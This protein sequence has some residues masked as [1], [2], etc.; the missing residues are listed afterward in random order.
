MSDLLAQ[1][2]ELPC[3]ADQGP[4]LPGYPLLG[5][6]AVDLPH[7]L[8]IV[9]AHT[10]E[11]PVQIVQPRKVSCGRRVALIY[12]Q[13]LTQQ[14]P[15]DEARDVLRSSRRIEQ[16]PEADL[17]PVVEFKVVAVSPW[18]GGFGSS[19]FSVCHIFM[20]LKVSRLGSETHPGRLL[21]AGTFRMPGTF[22]AYEKTA[23]YRH[24]PIK[25]ASRRIGWVRQSRTKTV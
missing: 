1:G 18:V 20:I 6:V 23:R 3:A 2:F 17:L 21:E 11:L 16:L 7:D 24:V 8:V 4:E 13:L 10:G 12:P 9:V 5:E 14:T 15:D 25:S 22:P 19:E